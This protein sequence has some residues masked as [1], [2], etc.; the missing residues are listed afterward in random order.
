MNEGCVFANVF[1]SVVERGTIIEPHCGP[2]NVRCH[3][4]H[5]TLLTPPPGGGSSVSS[6]NNLDK[7][8]QQQRQQPIL[9]VSNESI[10]WKDGQAFVFDDSL[11]HSVTFGS[12]DN[13]D[14]DDDDDGNHEMPARVVL[15]VDLWHHELTLQERQLITDLYRPS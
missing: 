15:I 3:R 8:Q 10:T 7:K 1:F 2:C 13:D 12:D 14:G 4:L 9:K 6:S 5:L 11:V